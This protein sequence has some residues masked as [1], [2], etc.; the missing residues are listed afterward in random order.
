MFLLSRTDSSRSQHSDRTA[1]G[2]LNDNRQI[3]PRMDGAV[4]VEGSTGIEWPKSVTIIPIEGVIIERC[5]ALLQVLRL[6]IL[7]LPL[8]MICSTATSSIN[9]IDCLLPLGPRHDPN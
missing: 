9:S 5:I 7:P 8:V 3:H 6:A 2:L 4:I 1:Q